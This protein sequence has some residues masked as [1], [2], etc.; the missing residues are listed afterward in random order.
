[1]EKRTWQGRWIEPQQAP[2]QEEATFTLAE[3]FSGVSKP[4]KPVE[5]R[6][7]APYLLKRIFSLADKPIAH[8]ELTMTAHGIYLAKING[9]PVSEAVFTP[10]YTSYASYLMYQQYD[11]T[12]LL[13]REN[14]W[15]VALADGWYGGRVSVSGGSAQF[16]N[17]LGILGEITVTYTDGTMQVIASDEAFHAT[18]G[19]YVYADIFIGEKQDLRLDKAEFDTEYSVEGLTPVQLAPYPLDNLV[20][21]NGGYVTRQERLPATRVWQEGESY[22]ID[23]GQV[24]AGRVKLALTL[25]DGETIT[26]EHSETLDAQGKFFNN[27]QGRNKDQRDVYIGRGGYEELEPDFTFHGFRY[28]R[29][30][31]FRGDISAVRFEAVVLHTQF[32]ETGHLHTCNDDINQLLSN[33]KWSQ[34]GNMLSIPTDCPQRERVGWTGDIQVFAPTASFFMDVSDFLMRWLDNVVCEQQENGEILDITPAPKDHFAKPSFTGAMSSAGWG[35]AI[36]FVPWTLY[37]RYGTTEP[38]SRY[39]DAMFKWQRFSRESAAGDKQGDAQYIWDTK[40]HYGDWLFPSLMADPSAGGPMATSK[41][42]RAL[43]GTA[44]LARSS[45]LLGKIA[46]ILG[47]SEQAQELSAY[48]RKV[49]AAFERHF[50]QDGRLAPDLQGSYVL[51][52]AFDLLEGKAKE[53]A[54]ARLVTLISENGNCLDTGFLSVPYL[55]PVLC[56]NGET[57]LAKTL[58]YQTNCPSWFY[59]VKMGATTIWETWAAILPDGTVTDR[60]LNHYAFGSVGDWIVREMIGLKHTKPGYQEFSIQPNPSLELESWDLEYESAQ[61]RIAFSKDRE[62]YQITV[63]QGARALVTLPRATSI[64]GQPCN[65]VD[66]VSLLGG[67]YRLEYR[68]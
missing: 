13:K 9:Q 17:R 5:E 23:F 26:L 36:I 44:F 50:F 48:H 65:G 41:M 7:Y 37:E 22:I 16:G 29:M 52:L 58:F 39:Y 66:R 3:M 35:D 1:M 19:K 11:I 64:N 47:H 32:Q 28:V 4:Q 31:G 46:A 30:T 27:I 12:A 59:E 33:I 14:V 15:S 60:S 10:D 45:E 67:S 38:L 25:Q 20:A 53:Q 62:C 6:L 63:P 40:F 34:K 55:L 43:V 57:E 8:A 21:Q 61:G 18:T 2:I 42:T 54:L 24:I 49:K 51:A 56:E 68:I